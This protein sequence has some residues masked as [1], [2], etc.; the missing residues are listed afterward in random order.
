MKD[1]IQDNGNNV[2]VDMD[3]AQ[4]SL[5]FVEVGLVKARRVT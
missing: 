1:D 4:L 5:D 3:A 2:H